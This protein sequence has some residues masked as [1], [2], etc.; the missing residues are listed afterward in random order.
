MPN[1]NTIINQASIY[2]PPSIV[3]TQNINDEIADH[4]HLYYQHRNS[5]AAL[6]SFCLVAGLQHN[7][8]HKSNNTASKVIAY[9]IQSFQLDSK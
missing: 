9:I 1:D 8:K 4:L 5:K 6:R 7:N 3:I 2:I